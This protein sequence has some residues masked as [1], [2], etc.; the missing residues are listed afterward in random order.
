MATS[1][2][3]Q[4]GSKDLLLE[5]GTFA[6]L[7]DGAAVVRYGD[8]MV[9][10]TC[11]SSAPREGIDFFPLTIDV[12]ERM[13]ARG[14]IPGSFFRREGR[15]SETAILTARLIDRPLRPSFREGYRDEVQ[16]VV[17]VLSVDME[18]QY[19]IPAMNAASLAVGIAGLPFDGPVGS[20]R[21][22]LIGS[23]W[24]VNPT[25]QELE[26]ATFDIVVAGSK[27]E[28]GGIDILMIEG[29][30]PDETWPLL[31]AGE[32]A[33]APTEEIVA[34]GLERAKEVITE[35]IGLQEEF[36]AEVGVKPS[37]FE[38]HP[39]YQQDLWDA[40][41]SFAK[42]KV[43][44]ALVSDRKEREANM[45]AV[46][47]E[48]KAHVAQT[49]G[50][51]VF[52]ARASEFS[53]AWKSLEKK[54]MRARVISDG[55]RLDGRGPKDIRPLAAHVGL[56]PRA[57]GSS[58]FE[59]GDTQVLNVTSLGMLRMNQMIDT[60]DPED[61]KRYIHH[62]NF[63][64]YSTGE[65]GRVGSPRRR[66]IGHGALAERALIPVVPSEEEFPYTLRLVSDVLSSNG[67]TSMAS[68]CASTLSLM[69]AGVPIKA[70]V[71][72][73]AMGM[74]AEGDTFVT[75]TDILGAEDALGDMDFK[76]AGTRE[77]VTAIQL[78]MKVSGMPA[79]VLAGALQQARE[80]RFTIL[81]VMEAAIP[82]PRDAVNPIAPRIITITIPVDK[83][84]EVIGPKGKRINEII[85]QTGADIDIQDDGTVFIGSHEGEGADEA[86]RMIDEIANP[87]PVLQGETY[88]GTV[89][90]TTTFGAFVNLVPGRD[91]LVHI[92]KLGKGKR[93]SSVEEAVREGDKLTVLVEDIDAQGKISLKPTGPEWEAPEGEGSS[94]GERREPREPAS[95]VSPA[96]GPIVGRVAPDAGS[97]T[98]TRGPR[99]KARTIRRRTVGIERTEFSSGLRVVTERMPGVRSVS[100][101]F[102]V[103]AGSRD[104]PPVISGSS[105]FLEHLL[106]KGTKTRSAR[107]IAED[108]DAVGGDVNAFTSKEYTC[109]YAR[110]LDGDL[111]MAVDHLSDMFQSSMLRSAD[112]DAERQVILE[113]INM[114]EDSPEEVVH[115]LFTE[116]LW[117]NH[118]LGRPVLGTAE[119]I[120]AATRDKVHRFYRKHYVPGGLV[121]AAA[122]NLRHEELLDML[123]ASHGHGTDRA[124]GGPAGME[125]PRQRDRARVLREAVG[126]AAQ[127]RAGAHLSRHERA[128][129]ERPG[130]VPLP[131]R[132]RRAGDR[133]VLAPVPGDPR[134][135]RPRLL[136]LQLSL[137]V[138]RG[139]AVLLLRG[140]HTR[141][142]AGGDRPAPSRAGR[143]RG[144]RSHGR[145]VR[146]R[147]GAREGVDGALA[148]GP[149][150]PDVE[151]RQVRDRARR[152]PHG[153]PVV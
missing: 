8:T 28:Q 132:E 101:G 110:I 147:E 153:E 18:N 120:R 14:K 27:N 84:G 37:D 23:D 20:V 128:R 126:E 74:I 121:V 68:V 122:G 112:L 44:S 130:P 88:D 98:P 148:R 104:E 135:A 1:K 90:K 140:D 75:L 133:D 99:P 4:I 94:G 9:L 5:S 73:I 124:V 119:T 113:E 102:W 3:K 143:R 45:S 97:A 47:D 38:P 150:E 85:A 25:F 127:D 46:K 67:S 39:L 17:T 129:A 30:A 16:V 65:T 136:G 7:A 51:D 117:P 125:P 26:E 107:E 106:F 55:V 58:L 100:L 70:P 31:A 139:G 35:I 64:P 6:K 76:V 53:P 52:A 36:L 77:F 71:G 61:S 66:E 116:A 86:A 32:G 146:S 118:P 56:L 80:A 29:E 152:D 91:G 137:A 87:R 63:P 21:L 115:D 48:A 83:I 50:E 12:E 40:L 34:Q 62:Y 134:E 24:V 138:H 108:F 151:D 79:D 15:P 89:V 145:G 57:H 109:Y 105:H 59:R 60:L 2:S 49:L 19:D 54:V 96:T 114:H 13:Y 11:V 149:R 82:A 111:E 93:L 78:D 92:S 22:G 123:R 81:D 69:D 10:A 95:R 41:E 131:D 103:L 144:G 43:L 33:T 142:R 72:G 141:P 42:D